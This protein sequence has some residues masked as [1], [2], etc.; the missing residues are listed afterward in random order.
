MSIGIFLVTD[1][2]P[3]IGN[4]SISLTLPNQWQ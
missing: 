3:S 2:E 4:P 1:L